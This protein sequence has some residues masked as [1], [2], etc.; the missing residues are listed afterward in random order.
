MAAL[1]TAP[2]QGEEGFSTKEAP[3]YVQQ[4]KDNPGELVHTTAVEDVNFLIR[5]D[6]IYQGTYTLD[7]TMLP[8]FVFFVLSL[9]PRGS[10]SNQYI[11]HVSQMF[12]AWTGTAEARARFVANAFNGGVFRIAYIPPNVSE[13]SIRAM[14]LA[15]LTAYPN[16]DLDPKNTDWIHVKGAD[17]RNVMFHWMTDRPDDTKPESFGGYLVGFV[18]APLVTG[19]QQGGAVQLYVEVKGDYFFLQPNPSFSVSDGQFAGPLSERSLNFIAS[20]PGCDDGICGNSTIC[21]IQVLGTATRSIGCG[22]GFGYG[23]NGTDP[24]QLSPATTWM[25]PYWL[26][27]RGA[28]T[29]SA[30]PLVRLDITHPAG[31]SPPANEVWYA[32]HSMKPGPNQL[33]T[34]AEFDAY[35]MPICETGSETSQ[36]WPHGYA[37]AAT[38]YVTTPVNNKLI[39]NNSNGLNFGMA[40]SIDSGNN[41]V[42]TTFPLNNASMTVCSPTTDGTPIA[43]AK[44]SIP[45]MSKPAPN[46]ESIVIFVNTHNRTMNYQTQYMAEDLKASV[47]LPTNS[48]YVYTLRVRGDPDPIMRLRLWPDGMWTAPPLTT[49]TLILK[50]GQEMYLQFEMILPTGSLMPQFTSLQ[51]RTLREYTKAGSRDSQDKRMKAYSAL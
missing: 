15:T 23:Y 44:C 30:F 31:T 48:T 35:N 22:F 40:F 49:D 14:S 33:P 6:Y 8:G 21:G 12:N 7:S 39:A 36:V 11:S 29:P 9:H 10:A 46:S 34:N 18:A 27:T 13:E 25:Q 4:T 41:S 45:G 50:P 32:I 1:G 5:H 42:P 16:I 26:E 38:W 37:A 20:Q 43:V 24:T 17:E 19:N 47:D 3:S 2:P 28:S 51:R